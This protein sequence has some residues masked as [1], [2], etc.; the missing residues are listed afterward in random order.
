MLAAN[1]AAGLLGIEFDAAAGPLLGDLEEAFATASA[2]EQQAAS[3]VEQRERLRD[4]LQLIGQYQEVLEHLAAAVQGLDG[5]SRL[6]VIPFLVERRDDLA[7]SEQ[8]LTSGLA[9]RFLLTEGAVG[10]LIVAVIIT[11]KRDAEAARGILA[12][13]GLHE[14]PRLGEYAR[15]DLS[16]MAAQLTDRSRLAPAELADVAAALRH[17]RQEATQELGSIWNRATDA[18]NRL[19]TLRAMASGRYGFALFGWVPVSRKPKVI[20]LMNR[21]GEPDTLYLRTRCRTS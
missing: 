17:L 1:H 21:L 4:E 3:L 5:S 8:E 9:D 2:W 19:H 10:N 6:A 20:E 7:V 16:T 12:H 11:L 13:E 15:M 14:L 18:A